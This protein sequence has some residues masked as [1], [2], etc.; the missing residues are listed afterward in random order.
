[1]QHLEQ[2]EEMDFISMTLNVLNPY[3]KNMGFKQKEQ[4][5]FNIVRCIVYY[6]HKDSVTWGGLDRSRGLLFETLCRLGR[7]LKS[8]FPKV[9]L[10]GWGEVCSYFRSD[11][12]K[13]QTMIG[14][15]KQSVTHNAS[16]V[17]E[18]SKMIINY[19]KSSFRSRDNCIEL[20]SVLERNPT[21]RHEAIDCITENS[22]H[23][24]VKT[25]LRLAKQEHEREGPSKVPGEVFCK[26]MFRILLMALARMD[27]DIKYTRYVD[28]LA[29]GT[30]WSYIKFFYEEFEKS[31]TAKVAKGAQFKK[32]TETLLKVCDVDAMLSFIEVTQTCKALCDKVKEI[33]GTN[34]GQKYSAQFDLRLATCRHWEY[35]KVCNEMITARGHLLEYVPNGEEVFREIVHKIRRDHKNKT[36]LQGLIRNY[37]S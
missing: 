8:E 33:V 31:G 2:V 19:L 21:A 22:K 16:L 5:L 11:P 12:E 6:D 4:Y 36:K 1:M 29:R 26:G 17:P 37:F 35:N 15:I 7:E 10:E 18:L 13:I 30:E 14:M 24:D 25:L 32:F 23:F 20:L 9:I 3:R 34:L 28:S 27:I